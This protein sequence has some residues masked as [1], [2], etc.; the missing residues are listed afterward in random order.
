MLTYLGE[1]E[2][3]ARAGACA[4]RFVAFGR[5]AVSWST[6]VRRT[7]IG[8]TASRVLPA[9]VLARLN[10]NAT[11]AGLGRQAAPRDG[12]NPV[13]ITAAV[14][15]TVPMD[16]RALGAGAAVS[17]RRVGAEWLRVRA[18]RRAGVCCGRTLPGGARR[19]ESVREMAGLSA[20]G[21][22][23]G[24]PRPPQRCP[25]PRRPHGAVISQR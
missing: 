21:R 2:V 9:E 4:N 20:A 1:A 11:S 24:W 18:R 19:R 10:R 14:A 15:R 25:A 12:Q 17:F 22:A 6:L 3:L 7:R 5:A 8:V 16:S 23:H 13:A